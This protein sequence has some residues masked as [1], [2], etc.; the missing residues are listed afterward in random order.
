MKMIKGAI[1]GTL[2][3]MGSGG[4]LAL[5][6]NGLLP[7]LHAAAGDQAVFVGTLMY[8]VGVFGGIMGALL[9]GTQ[10]PAPTPYAELAIQRQAA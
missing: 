9:G 2:I 1:N 3:G 10:E 5:G 7:S 8:G 6:L 4:V